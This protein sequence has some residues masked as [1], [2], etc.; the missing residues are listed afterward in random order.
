MERVIAYVD[1]FNLYFGLKAE[2]LKRFYWLDLVALAGALLK[3]GQQLAAT[4]YF[5]ARI[6]DN[7]HNTPDRKRQNDYIEALQERGAQVQL[8]HYLPKPRHCRGCGATWTDY[9]EKETDVNIAI[10]L[11]LDAVDDRFDTALLISADSDLTTP[12]R[13][14]RARCP[15]KR[16]IAVFPPQRR[17]AELSKAA[18]GHLVLGVDKLRISQLPETI[19]K[20]GGYVLRRPDTWK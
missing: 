18:H 17:S 16:I 3:P 14:V 13:R 1:G 9:E 8:G 10:Q 15:G 19:T 4:Q 20:P 5:T 2:S 7:G 6:R 12:V 11:L